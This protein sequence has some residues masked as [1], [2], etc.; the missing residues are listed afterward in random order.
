MATAPAT[1][2]EEMGKKK[3]PPKASLYVEISPALRKRF[4]RVAKANGRKLNAELERALESH[5]AREEAR[6]AEEEKQAGGDG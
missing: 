3:G 6:L 4:E 1:E 2:L 5:C